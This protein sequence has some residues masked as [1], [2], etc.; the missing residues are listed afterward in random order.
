M[1]DDIDSAPMLDVYLYSEHP[2]VVGACGFIVD[3]VLM[4]QKERKKYWK[5]VRMLIT[6]LWV[7]ATASNNPWRSFSRDRMAY[8]P[9]TRYHQIY[10]SFLVVSIVD[11]LIKLG[12]I[13]QIK[14]KY[15]KQ[16][17]YGR[18]SRICATDKLLEMI[19]IRDI[20]SVLEDNPDDTSELV[21]L[22][23]KQKR[24]IDYKD[25]GRTEEA[26]EKLK[27]INTLLSGTRISVN[28]KALE[29]EDELGPVNSNSYIA[30]I[31][32]Y[33]RA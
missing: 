22:R 17:G 13:E 29:N 32:V 30:C 8:Q 33:C 19:K 3:S 20:H 10:I 21:F 24:L 16:T 4:P 28:R 6:N 1:K 12:Y 26:R 5:A 2:K 18:V 7:S 31:Q 27:R 15:D 23:D 9:K 11:S 25:N 14:G